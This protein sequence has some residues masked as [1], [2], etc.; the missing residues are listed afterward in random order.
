MVGLPSKGANAAVFITR[1]NLNPSSFLVEFW[2]N[3]DQDRKLAY[4][5]LKKEIQFPCESFSESDGTPG[6][7]CLVRVYKTWYRAR[8]MSKDADEY[9]VFLIDEGRTL[10]ATANT[11]AWGKSDY[12]Y[13]PAEVEF[14]VLAN[15]LPLSPENKWSVMAQ[16]F[17][18]TFCGRRVTATIQDVIV[19]HRT[20]LLDIPSLSRQMC[21]MG[22]SKKLYCDQ[23]REFVVRSLDASRGTGELKKI[24]YIRSNPEVLEKKEQQQVYMYPELQANTV[25]TVVVTEVTSPFRIF[26][27]LKVFSQ[28][29][30][31]LTGQITQYYEGRAGSNFARSENLGLPCASRGSDGQWYRSVLQQIMPTNNLVEVLHV[32]YGKK[33]FVQADKVMPLTSEFFRMPVVTYVCSLH[34]IVDRGVGWTASQIEFLKSLLLN[35]TVIA[36][37]QYQSLS[38]GVQYVT[39]YGE[40]NT[41]INRLFETKQQHSLDSDMILADYAVQKSTLS[42]KS[43]MLAEHTHTEKKQS[44]LKVF[45]TESLT[46]NTSHLAVV[47]HVESPGMFWIQT[48]RYSEEFNQLMDDLEH[49]YSDPTS[50][51]GL[52]RK[53]LVGQLCAAKSQDGAFYRAAVKNVIDKTAEVYFLD[54]GNVELVDCFNLKQLPMRFQQL[55][56]VA[57]KC[58]LY[59]IKSRQKCWDERA[60][61]YFSKLVKDKVLD[62]HVQKKQQDTLMV[63]LVDHSSAGETDVS[64]LLCSAGFAEDEK[65][66]GD[67]SASKPESLKVT[68]SSNVFMTPNQPPMS[69][70]SIAVTD[71]VSAFKEYLFPIGSS[72]EV[73]VSYIESPN[74]F[75]CQKASNA[76]C[77][78]VLMQDMQHYYEHSE[79]HPLMDSACV[80]QHPETGIWYRALVIQKHQTPHVDVLFVDYGQMAKVAIE[81][82]RKITP[83]FLKLKGQAFRCSLYNLIHPVSLSGLGWSSEATLAFQEF[84][85]SSAC[86]NVPLKCTIFAV[87]YDLQ[88]VVFNVVDLETPFQSICNLLVQKHLADRAPATR[89][90]LAPF[91]LDTYYYSTHGIKI[92]CEEEVST[93]CVK[94]VNQFFCHLER[95][96]DEIEKLTNKVNSLCHQ[97]E[98]TKCPQTFGTVCF[99]KYTDGLWYRGQI[100]SV[101]PSIVVNFVDYGDTLQV[102]KTELLPVPIEAGEIMSVPVQAV[103][104]ALSDMPENVPVDV[105]NWFCKFADSHCFTALIVA[106]E[107]GGK[108]FVELYEG[109][110]QINSLIR[111]KFHQEINKD[112]LCRNY[113]SKNAS[114]ERLGACLKGRTATPKRDVLDQVPQSCD[115]AAQQTKSVESKQRNDAQGVRTDRQA[116]PTKDTVNNQKQDKPQRKS[117]CQSDDLQLCTSDT[118]AAVKPKSM[119]LLKESTLPAK[120]IQPGLEDKVF[121]SHCH[122]SCSFFVQ[123]AADEL[124][125]YALVDKLN[126]N[127]SLCKNVNS[128]DICEGDLV[129][130]MFPDDSSWYRAAVRKTNGDKIDVE[131]LD[132]GNTAVVSASKI[133]RLDQTLASF[134]RYSIH[135]CVHKLNV[136][137]EDQALDPYF[138]QVIEQNTDKC[139]CSFV[140]M[141]G[142]IWEVKL[143]SN[144]VVFGSACKEDDEPQ[145][146]LRPDIVPQTSNISVCTK[147]K[148]PEVSVGQV[149]SGYSSFVKGPQ[150]F[151]CQIEKSETL[152]EISEVLQK[153]ANASDAT[154]EVLAVG[155]VCM[156]QFTEDNLWYRAKITA[157]DTDLLSITF[158]DYGNESKVNI[159]DVK[160]LPLELSDVPPQAFWCQL[161]GF[162]PSQ[163]FWDE[164]ADD[165]FFELTNDQ[166]LKISI[167][168]M[169]DSDMPHSVKLHCND[170]LINDAMRKYW[171]SQSKETPPTKLSCEAELPSAVEIDSNVSLNRGDD[172]TENDCCSVQELEDSGQ[173]RLNLLS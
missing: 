67:H 20:F 104:C 16:E 96:V 125:I 39:L 29:L 91:R 148:E 147:V 145:A 8:I 64:K 95:N 46:P 60:T 151:W 23:F 77:L 50:M 82:L 3:F 41:N 122:S 163:G 127:Q 78:D 168:K 68:Q 32:D 149:F 94:S 106:K 167:E 164:K 173:D 161:E 81:N 4:Q 112:V 107:P 10:R 2:G 144:G 33:Q 154:A 69:T 11:L 89:S 93:T 49:L 6:D 57:V 134:P 25:E 170:E 45:F 103:E 55:P 130:A 124:E 58:S 86:M 143:N 121:V 114:G 28:E 135:C 162:D 137:G 141:S 101:K 21:E 34:G 88:K 105:E 120:V 36:K 14:C 5:Q 44:D 123:L 17:M 9:N 35:R 22:F 66:L 116:N 65:F 43:K 146:E 92:G 54:Y 79:F 90:P 156:A 126:S 85:D 27:Q 140:K 72:L 119:P 40:E 97:L 61:L 165:A 53:P 38:E 138:K 158:I 157:K 15:V 155:N 136:E 87:M 160:A 117:S 110:T 100:K 30:K 80:A 13:L 63:Q 129:C 142:N 109:K 12:F 56:A 131:F 73:I 102:E 26:C 132:Y 169:G 83:A 7:L 139:L 84:V 18:K 171:R 99:A 71:S 62:L 52:I 118:T 47:Q 24:S 59:G 70:T 108:L 19:A 113:G 152:Q 1:V 172:H 159:K 128:S 111:Q 74:D 42:Q 150:L 133:C 75:W 98:L 37:F 115:H 31:K 76:A 51:K 166:L 153:A 48:Q